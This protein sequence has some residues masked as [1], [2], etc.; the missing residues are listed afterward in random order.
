MIKDFVWVIY[1]NTTKKQLQFFNTYAPMMHYIKARS[2][3]TI[4]TT[5]TLTTHQHP[6][7]RWVDDQVLVDLARVVHADVPVGEV[8]LWGGR[9]Q[10]LQLVGREGGRGAAHGR[11]GGVLVDAHAVGVGGGGDHIGEGGRLGRGDHC[12]GLLLLLLLLLLVF[13]QRGELGVDLGDAVSVFKDVGWF[14]VL[15][16]K[17]MEHVIVM[18]MKCDAKDREGVK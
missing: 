10:R 13:G 18:V 5:Q 1:N 7:H 14:Q 9:A 12:D 4:Q 11:L 8:R 17:E 3:P 6:T 16:W 2:N 15:G